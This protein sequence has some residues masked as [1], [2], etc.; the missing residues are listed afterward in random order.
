MEK[1]KSSVTSGYLMLLVLLVLIGITVWGIA[2]LNNLWF[3][4]LT[5]FI[6]AIV[7]GFLV[8]YPNE[9]FVLTL[10]GQYAGT[11]KKTGF[12]WVNPFF[13]K[14]RIS[15]RARNFDSSRVKVNDKMGNPIEIGV[16]LVWKVE[17]TFKAAFDV[18]DYE[19]FVTIQSEAAVRKLAGAYPYDSLDDHEATI[20]LRSGGDEI[21]DRLENELTERL[22]MA[23]IRV[24]E[25]RISHLAY[26]QEIAHAMLQRQQATAIVAARTKIV[27]G[28]VGMVEMAL[29]ELSKR[30][31]IDLDNDKRA[32]M[33]SNLMVVLCS[34][35]SATPVVNAGTLHQ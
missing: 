27:E 12:A 19:T 11:V 26:A 6:M 24:L 9:S 29:G 2:G 33:A 1:I 21:H 23:G 7:P 22:A 16:I 20:S 30:E 35:R 28:A 14:R 15:L 18:N 3:L 25:S 8:I 5:P 31:L 13:I 10:F 32:A 4:A 17:E 34:D